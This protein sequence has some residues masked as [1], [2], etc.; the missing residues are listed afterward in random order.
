MLH[1]NLCFTYRCPLCTIYYYIHNAICDGIRLQVLYP[2]LRE[3]LLI[4]CLPSPH[5]QLP[6]MMYLVCIQYTCGFPNLV[7][8]GLRKEGT[9]YGME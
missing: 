9:E 7:V 3:E 5:L 8:S 1:L 6:H 4:F 2:L